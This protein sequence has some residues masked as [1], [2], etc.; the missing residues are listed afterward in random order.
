V[1]P[2]VVYSPRVNMAPTAFGPYQLAKGTMVVASH[3]ITHHLPE[4]FPQPERFLPDRW[5][6]TAPSPYA[7]MPFG[8]GSRMCVGAPFALLMLKIAVP[9]IVQRFRL[10]VEPGVRI[11]RHCT[12][13][14]GPRPGIP[15]TVH[16]QDRRFSASAVQGNIHELVELPGGTLEREAA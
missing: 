9:V 8:A 4:I 7:Y 6:R 12:L 1:L 16:E 3:Y 15:V 11:D 2:P 5:L 13:T 10:S 14:L